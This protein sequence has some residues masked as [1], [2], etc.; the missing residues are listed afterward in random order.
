[1]TRKKI[2]NLLDFVYSL[3]VKENRSLLISKLN[4]F[5]QKEARFHWDEKIE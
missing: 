5:N 2:V 1:M 4:D 3:S